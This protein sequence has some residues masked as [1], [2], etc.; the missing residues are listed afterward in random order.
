MQLIE[1][2]DILMQLTKNTIE[3]Q[4]SIEHFMHISCQLKCLQ[5]QKNKSISKYHL[6][7]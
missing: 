3:V 1:Y 5:V 6:R 2:D 7:Q 4:Y